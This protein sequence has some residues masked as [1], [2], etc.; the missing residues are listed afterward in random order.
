MITDLTSLRWRKNIYY[1]SDN[2][3]F[4]ICNRKKT[5]DLDE[6]GTYI[7]DIDNAPDFVKNAPDGAVIDL[8][9]CPE[10]FNQRESNIEKKRN[11]FHKI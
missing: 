8:R 3:I 7:I 11:S 2:V 10:I 6:C 5:P 4:D 1:T 9:S